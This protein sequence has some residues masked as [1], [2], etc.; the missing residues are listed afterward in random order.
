[1][2]Q[3]DEDTKKRRWNQATSRMSP[4]LGTVAAHWVVSLAPLKIEHTSYD[5][6]K[7]L[8]SPAADSKFKVSKETSK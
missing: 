7:K 4:L 3:G 6:H 8:V 2:V 5:K 1:M